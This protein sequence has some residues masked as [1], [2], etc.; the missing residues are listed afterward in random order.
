MKEWKLFVL[1][2]HR[3][4]GSSSIRA[5]LLGLLEWRWRR[6]GLSM[7]SVSAPSR[8]LTADPWNAD[9]STDSVF[10]AAVTYRC[11]RLNQIHNCC[12]DPCPL[13]RNRIEENVEEKKKNPTERATLPTP[14]ESLISV[15]FLM[16]YTS[17]QK[18]MNS[19][20]RNKKPLTFSF[21]RFWPSQ[22]ER[23]QKGREKPHG[24]VSQAGPRTSHPSSRPHVFNLMGHS[25]SLC[26][27][28]ASTLEKCSHTSHTLNLCENAEQ[29]R[30]IWIY[31]T[32]YCHVLIISL[33]ILSYSACLYQ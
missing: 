8:L 19:V 18:D 23:K 26:N 1:L 9:T 2:P 3:G 12:F 20:F 10:T 24:L 30:R 7:H 15:H 5:R 31:C 27:F 11:H 29:D 4:A 17:V 16:H 33:I 13:G 22:R 32:A 25:A 6:K 14:S 28:K 21:N